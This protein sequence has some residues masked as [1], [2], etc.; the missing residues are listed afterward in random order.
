MTPLTDFK[1]GP[2]VVVNLPYKALSGRIELRM[3]DNALAAV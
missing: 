3:L 2:A 1:S